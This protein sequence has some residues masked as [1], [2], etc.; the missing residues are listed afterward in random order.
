MKRYFFLFRNHLETYPRSFV[1][2]NYT[3][4][5]QYA[6]CYAE[7]SGATLIKWMNVI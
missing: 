2:K 3:A 1:A 5:R 4:A 7:M 6:Q